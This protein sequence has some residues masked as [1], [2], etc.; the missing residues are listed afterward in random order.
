MEE[1]ILDSIEYLQMVINNIKSYQE[2]LDY[3]SEILKAIDDIKIIIDNS[4]KKYEKKSS[5]ISSILGLQFD[6]DS[7]LKEEDMKFF[8]K[9]EEDNNN[10]NNFYNTINYKNN[11]NNI[12]NRNRFINKLQ[13]NY[14]KNNDININEQNKKIDDIA[15]IIFKINNEDYIS[16]ILIKLFGNN[17]TKRLLSEN[18]SN[19]LVESVKNTIQE[20]ERIKQNENEN[21]K[22]IVAQKNKIIQE[23]AKN[24]TIKLKKGK[25][26]NK[27]KYSEPYQEFN[28][29]NYLRKT[30]SKNLR[31]EVY[32][33]KQNK[34]NSKNKTN[35][36][37]KKIKPFVSATCGYGKYFDEPLQ[38]GGIS[39]LEHKNKYKIK[40]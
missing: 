6:Y 18:V 34:S 37:I 16:D 14:K 32:S 22:N 27:F 1:K 31:D 17:I 30:L 33:I 19:T 3:K 9:Y 25:I 5:K 20:I 4:T 23:E 29:K 11:I 26:T 21:N 8:S 15:D 36:K 2:F 12:N 28:F 40:I 13:K 35:K 24:D 7:Y 39:V 38:N 10:K